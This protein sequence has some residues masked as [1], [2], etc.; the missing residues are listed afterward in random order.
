MKFASI[1]VAATALVA[2]AVAVA[3]TKPA[4]AAMAA[5]AVKVSATV[6]AIDLPNRI[7]TLKAKNGEVTLLKVGPEVKNL[8]Q[9]KVGDV[10]TT[11]YA[12]AVAVALKKG[13][14]GIASATEQ[15]ASGAAKAGEKPAGVMTNTTVLVANVIAVNKAKKTVTVKGPAG[16]VLTLAVKDPAVLAQVKVGDQVEATY[17]EAVMVSVTTPPAKK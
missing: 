4:P 17:T 13:G 1:L 7:V 16:N 3:Q 8:A 14:D 2:S 6:E 12:Q 15:S 5:D 10:V 11:R 9:V